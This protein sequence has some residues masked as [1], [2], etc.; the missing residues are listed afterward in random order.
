MIS[1]LVA[2]TIILFAELFSGVLLCVVFAMAYEDEDEFKRLPLCYRVAIWSGI[3]L[4]ITSALCWIVAGVDLAA[5]GN[6]A[7]WVAAV[8]EGFIGACEVF[9]V[10][11]LLWVARWKRG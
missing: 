9:S 4:L 3:A 2:M 6:A 1:L 8:I 5:N 7:A 10:L 11:A